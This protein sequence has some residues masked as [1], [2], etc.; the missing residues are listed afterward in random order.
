[1]ATRAADAHG[2]DRGA[3]PLLSGHTGGRTA[4]DVLG[5][6]RSWLSTGTIVFA[7][8]ESVAGVPCLRGAAA[9][10]LA[11]GEARGRVM[12]GRFAGLAT[13]GMTVLVIDH[14][15]ADL[16]TLPSVAPGHPWAVLR[17]APQLTPVQRW[18]S[19]AIDLTALHRRLGAAG[20]SG[21]VHA[22]G[23]G[24]LWREGQLVAAAVDDARDD[25]ALAGLRRAIAESGGEVALTPLDGRTASALHGLALGQR[26][27]G[28]PNG[29][30][31]ADT[32]QVA[33]VHRSQKEFVVPVGLGRVGTFVA[34]ERGNEAPLELPEESTDWQRH[35]YALTLRGRD[36]LNPMTER[37]S[38]F[39]REFGGDGI[40]LLE[41]VG[42][43][44]ALDAVALEAGGDLDEL[45]RHAERWVRDGLL[46]LV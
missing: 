37:H 25:A 12:M 15:A 9:L 23:A 31:I 6:L 44:R 2:S 19:G 14:A 1:M 8:V 36:A 33:F 3:Q 28:V 38:Q 42:R 7:H 43:A 24:A 16:P 22:G 17:A 41:A 26:G 21:I 46:R 5:A 11:H 4:H 10:A 45:R 35:R 34:A 29:G 27:Q 30:L 20:W 13:T 32:D 40:R 39:A 18:P